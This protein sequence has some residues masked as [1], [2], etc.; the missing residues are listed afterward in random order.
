M[1]LHASLPVIFHPPQLRVPPV[2]LEILQ[3]APPLL[4]KPN[5]KS[6]NPPVSQLVLGGVHTMWVKYYYQPVGIKINFIIDIISSLILS[7]VFIVYHHSSD[8]SQN[9]HQINQRSGLL[10]IFLFLSSMMYFFPSI[11]LSSAIYYHHHHHHRNQI[12]YLHAAFLSHF[13]VFISISDSNHH[14][15]Y[16]QCP[17]CLHHH[18]ITVSWNIMVFYI[19][20]L[21]S[22]F[23]A[24]S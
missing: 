10:F 1:E 19:C 22:Y 9:Y 24:L 17:T 13:L 5:V 7:I 3:P 23:L 15:I 12:L 2:I 6:F 20:S 21:Q 4:I 14:N 16:C 8:Y 11:L 18:G